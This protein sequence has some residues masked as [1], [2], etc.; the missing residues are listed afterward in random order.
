LK[1]NARKDI[2]YGIH[3]MYLSG[4]LKKK[5]LTVGKAPTVFLFILL[6]KYQI[7]SY[8]VQ[9]MGTVSQKAKL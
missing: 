7:T 2:E 4:F 1:S 3:P 6:Y 8:T 9:L 5:T